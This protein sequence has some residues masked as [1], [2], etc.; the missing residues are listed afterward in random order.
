M[1][2]KWVGAETMGPKRWLHCHLGPSAQDTDASRALVT[3]GKLFFLSF[4]VYFFI[5]IM[6]YSIY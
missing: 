4:F 2:G 6:F 5:L 1:G 3:H